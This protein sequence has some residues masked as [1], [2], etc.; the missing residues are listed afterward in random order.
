MGQRAEFL[1]FLT[2]LYKDDSCDYWSSARKYYRDYE[3]T[4]YD[5][6]KDPLTLEELGY[7]NNKIVALR[8]NYKDEELLDLGRQTLLTQLKEEKNYVS[9]SFSFITGRKSKRAKSYCLMSAAVVKDRTG[10]SINVFYRATEATKKFGADLIFLREVFTEFIPE[11]LLKRVRYVKFYFTL[12]Y[13]VP[14][15]F[16]LAYLLGVR[17][18]PDRNDR[19]AEWCQRHF[20]R[21]SEGIVKP[22]FGPTK[23]IYE[24]FQKRMKR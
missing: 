8:K 15:Y 4:V 12:L 14:I 7:V 9:A 6:F 22:K 20:D 10:V 24:N 13:V 19:M 16:P 23:R 21:A 11:E 5:F 17:I 1:S 2:E 3:W 18:D